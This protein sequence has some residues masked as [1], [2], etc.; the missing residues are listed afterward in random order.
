MF[1]IAFPYTVE[2]T[3]TKIFMDRFNYYEYQEEEKVYDTLSV[4]GIKK[5]D[6]E[7]I[8]IYRYFKLKDGGWV[9][10][11]KTEYFTRK[12]KFLNRM[13]KEQIKNVT[14]PGEE[15]IKGVKD[16]IE[17][18]PQMEVSASEE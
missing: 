16:G 1:P 3:P 12:N 11:D 10:I 8:E 14:E 4:C 18:K 9:E 13:R 7:V 5:P 2:A 17:N 15:V 6:G